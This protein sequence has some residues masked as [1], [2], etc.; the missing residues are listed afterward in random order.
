LHLFKHIVALACLSIIL[1]FTMQPDSGSGN[2]FDGFGKLFDASVKT[3]ILQTAI[4]QGLSI[5]DMAT[6]QVYKPFLNYLNSDKFTDAT[7]KEI[8]TAALTKCGPDVSLSNV[9]R[10]AYVAMDEKTL[11]PDG[12]YKEMAG[13]IFQRVTKVTDSNFNSILKNGLTIGFMF[14]IVNFMER[15][16]GDSFGK[17]VKTLPNVFAFMGRMATKGYNKL[18]RRPEALNPDEILVWEQ[19]FEGLLSSLCEQN[20]SSNLML[21]NLRIQ[22]ESKADVPLDPNWAYFAELVDDMCAHVID[23][24]RDHMAHYTINKGQ[25]SYLVKMA[26]G[27]ESENKA[28]IAFLMNCIIKNLNNIKEVCKRTQ[29]VDD[30]DVVHIKKLGRITLLLFKK[31]RIMLHGGR[32]NSASM[33]S[34]GQSITEH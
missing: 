29:Q 32:Q 17:V 28:T 15:M 34:L 16:I 1:T 31:L 7:R 18:A 21:K 10:N 25:R 11:V 33:G 30:L 5:Q 23:Y 8:F 13:S 26:H 12:L 3:S 4:P 9:C 27:V 24:L 19:T 6:I 2:P 22:D 20:T 14:G